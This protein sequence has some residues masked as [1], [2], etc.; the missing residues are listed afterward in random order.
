[1]RTRA[2]EHI[3]HAQFARHLLHIDRTPFVGEAR[4]TRDDKQPAD[5]RQRRDDLLDHTVG[6]IFLFRVATHILKR[7]HRD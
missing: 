5:A 4:I 6:E 2:F 7:Q 3:A 1:L